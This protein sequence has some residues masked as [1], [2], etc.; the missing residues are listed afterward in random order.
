MGVWFEYVQVNRW[1]TK[2]RGPPSLKES[3]AKTQLGAK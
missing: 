2:L 1:P 3:P